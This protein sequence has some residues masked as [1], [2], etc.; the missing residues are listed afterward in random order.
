[1]SLLQLE[2]DLRRAIERNELCVYY[3]P[4]VRL[5]SGAMIGLEALLRWQHPL[6]GLLAPG[7]FLMIAEET[8]M[9][10]PIGWWVM[11]EACLQMRRWHA[12]NPRMSTLSLNINLSEKQLI[13][14]DAVARISAILEE[15]GMPGELLKLEITEHTLLAHNEAT[16]S[17]LHQIRELGIHLCIDDFGT[18]YSSLN[19]L[20]RFPINVL[21]IDRS[22]IQQLGRP[23]EQSELV[24]TIISLA[25]ALNLQAVAEGTETIGQVQ[26]LRRL[27]CEFGQG[28][29]FS[30]ALDAEAIGKL[31]RADQPLA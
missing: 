24:H 15:T 30:K 31:V 21:K 22:F 9:I 11:R 27:H 1:M 2:S 3:Q 17:K 16:I 26:E 19:Y 10:V 6:K 29:L 5:D 20:Q 12:E 7:E 8:G 28:W 18:G 13:E 14:P 23:G 4:I 25:N